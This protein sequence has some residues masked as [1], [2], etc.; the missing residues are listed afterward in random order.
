MSSSADIDSGV[1]G[2]GGLRSASE[3]LPKDPH[4]QAFPFLDALDRRHLNR[5][6]GAQRLSSTFVWVNLGIAAALATYYSIS[7]SWSGTRGALV[8]LIL[9]GARGHLRQLRS[10]RL[11]GKLVGSEARP[12]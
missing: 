10:A 8:V 5:M 3:S 7:S 12:Q 6:L 9:L 4:S 2:D 11:L 1:A